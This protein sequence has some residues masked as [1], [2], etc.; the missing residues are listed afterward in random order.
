VKVTGADGGT[1]VVLAE[2]YDAT[3]AGTFRSTSSPRLI[4]ASARTQVDVGDNVLI[5]GFAVG[6]STS[7]TVLIRAIG[8]T[9][10]GFGVNG[11][12]ADPKLELSQGGT[13]IAANDDWGGDAQLTSVGSGVGAFPL[14]SGTSKDAILLV[15]LPPGTYAAKV[16]GAN[17]GTGVALVELYDI[18]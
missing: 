1:G 6:G 3:P 17:S 14:P 13:I 10:T 11:A 12:L 7:K 18:P 9:L 5:A 15:T 8:P 16:F 4:N 2:L